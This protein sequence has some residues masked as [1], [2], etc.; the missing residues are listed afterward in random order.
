MKVICAAYAAVKWSEDDAVAVGLL[1][2]R[3]WE[4]KE[5]RIDGMKV[6]FVF[7]LK[8]YLRY[9]LPTYLRLT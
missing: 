7:L 4:V 5:G 2:F 9:I 6:F 1:I 3:L 8:T